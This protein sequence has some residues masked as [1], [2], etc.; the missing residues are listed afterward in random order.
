[1][2]VIEQKELNKNE[3][4]VKFKWDELNWNILSEMSNGSCLKSSIN[5]VGSHEWQLELYPDGFT[6]E[7]KGFL[8]F[9]LKSW[10]VP[11]AKVSCLFSICND[12]DAKPT[13]QE[14]GQVCYNA[15]GVSMGFYV[16]RE[17]VQEL[18]TTK[19]NLIIFCKLEVK[20]GDNFVTR[21]TGVTKSVNRVEELD[22]FEKLLEN[23][24]AGDITLKVQETKIIYADKKILMEKSKY[25]ADL[26]SKN[27]T[28]QLDIK[29]RSYETFMEILRFIYSGKVHNIHKFV[30]EV[31]EV[32]ESRQLSKLAELCE[33]VIQCKR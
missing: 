30:K 10:N 1:M 33:N 19:G 27:D 22:D 29:V 11:Y 8:T 13:Q 23:P 15:L 28:N 16:S 24:L 18:L 17:R 6:K 14:R 5:K 7:D 2:S 25:F 4:F 26:L 31:K 21:P 32:A 20:H 12:D 3:Y 9:F